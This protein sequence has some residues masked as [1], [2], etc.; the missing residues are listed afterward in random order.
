MR[1]KKLLKQFGPKH[2]CVFLFAVVM[3]FNSL[4][5]LKVQAASFGDSLNNSTSGNNMLDIQSAEEIDMV[6]E[7]KMSH[8]SGWIPDSLRSVFKLSGSPESDDTMY[9]ACLDNDGELPEK[10]TS[11]DVNKYN[12]D[13]TKGFLHYMAGF[14]GTILEQRPASGVDYVSEKTYAL[15]HPG[16]VLADEP[17]YYSPGTGY[18][19]LK[20]IQAF[21]GWSV[22]LVYGV[23]VIIIIFVA[24]AIM[25]RNRIPGSASITL[26]NAIPSIAIAMI[27]VPLSYAISGL[28]IDL[29]TIG[30]NAGHEFV[31]G[32]GS[33]GRTIYENRDEL[34]DD[35][36]G[37]R[38]PNESADDR[39]L[40]ADDK[41]VNWFNMSS[42]ADYSEEGEELGKSMGVVIDNV[43]LGAIFSILDIFG[44]AGDGS[45]AA[46][47]GTV[48]NFFITLFMIYTGFKIFWH[49]L[50]KYLTLVVMP[51][52]SPFIFATMAIP[53]NGTKNI[54]LY[55]K[56]LGAAATSYIVTYVMFLFVLLFSSSV[57]QDMS[58]AI[59]AP[60]YVPPML[61]ITAI[62]KSTVSGTG[63]D[64]VTT[65]LFSLISLGI[66][67]SIPNV[68]KSIDTAFG[69]KEALPAFFTT[70]FK[71]LNESV[72][73]TSFATAKTARWGF[74]RGRDVIKADRARFGVPRANTALRNYLDK[75]K[76]L[77]PGKAGTWLSKQR[78]QISQELATAERDIGAAERAYAS[79]VA[80]GD[81][82]GQK[83]ALKNLR[84]AQDRKAGAEAKAKRMN[85]EARPEKA[86]EMP[87]LEVKFETNTKAPIFNLTGDDVVTILAKAGYEVDAAGNVTPGPRT[88][89]NTFT[90]GGCVLSFIANNFDFPSEVV[91]QVSEATES[92]KAGLTQMGFDSTKLRG[93][94]GRL[95]VETPA[96][97]VNDTVF[98]RLK[99]PGPG[100]IVPLKFIISD[101]KGGKPK[102]PRLYET[103][104]ML[105]FEDVLALFGNKLDTQTRLP[106]NGL[107]FKNSAA[108]S[109]N[110]A[111]KVGTFETEKETKIVV[112]M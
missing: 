36:R 87:R 2:L 10:L 22:N 37:T 6:Y 68:L 45:N 31:L 55:A 61:G 33:P 24:F 46:W 42:I 44:D 106:L 49:L 90:I 23:L 98:G 19:L 102:T 69:V 99:V 41:R 107:I 56:T 32:A 51:I 8:L 105:I 89:S 92:T 78:S 79:A 54:I 80:G 86:E 3:L 1:V 64:L 112:A 52:F 11:I 95:D 67:F 74:N 96:T 34:G 88:P 15:A 17:G 73:A 66:Y 93:N 109:L 48:I 63:G 77:T 84:D 20:P 26:Q 28:F 39:G 27:L 72:K 65:L 21:W 103:N 12:K 35:K 5:I 47:F 85:I 108:V 40:F 25:F 83:T 16:R 75:R 9:Q 70:P 43:I 38:I 94:G 104:G 110:I 50:K 7:C 60:S 18:D 101:L 30:T 111:F 58:V 76:G 91:V 57:F 4:L 53:G 59:R 82:K 14:T 29:I 81:P 100:P 97:P 13:S 71:E 62:L